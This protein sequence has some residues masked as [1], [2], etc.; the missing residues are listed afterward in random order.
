MDSLWEKQK[1]LH[2]H[3]AS[4]RLLHH[5]ESSD[6]FRNRANSVPTLGF[7]TRN[8]RGEASVF[9]IF[10]AAEGLLDHDAGADAK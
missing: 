8:T 10:T 5:R 6:R 7:T 3:F 2:C 1:F 4:D 9:Q